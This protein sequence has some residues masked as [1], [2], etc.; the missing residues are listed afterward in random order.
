VIR[1]SSQTNSRRL[2][3]SQSSFPYVILLLA[4]IHNTWLLNTFHHSKISLVYYNDIPKKTR[5]I[6]DTRS[7]PLFP[8]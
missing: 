6:P 7:K 2:P 5:L 3:W 4:F 1:N 8:A